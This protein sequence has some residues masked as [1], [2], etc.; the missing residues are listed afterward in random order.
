LLLPGTLIAGVMGMNFHPGIFQHAVL[1]WV[2]NAV[3]VLIALATLALARAR[4]WI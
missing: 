2:V 4:R 1:F 3:I